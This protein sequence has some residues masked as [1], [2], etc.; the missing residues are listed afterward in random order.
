MP[1][2]PPLTGMEALLRVKENAELVARPLAW[3]GLGIGLVR[4]GRNFVLYPKPPKHNL[5]LSLLTEW[6]VLTKRELERE[7][8]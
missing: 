6:E 5:K 4:K 3:S 2:T 1:R 8:K 7:A